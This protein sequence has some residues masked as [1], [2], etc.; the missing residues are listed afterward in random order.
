M[1]NNT[2]TIMEELLDSLPQQGEVRWLG[3]RPARGEAMT[4]TDSVEARVGTGLAG[5][6]YQGRGGKREVTLI[7]WE[8][9]SVIANLLG[10]ASVNAATLRRNI[11]VSGIN[12]L[13]LRN[14]YFRIGTAILQGVDHCHPCS[15]ME[16]ALGVGGYNAVRGHGGITAR[17]IRPGVIRRGDAVALMQEDDIL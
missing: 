5:D 8:H 1:K 15:K 16:Y 7:Q 13:A 10:V 11:A 6:R 14:Q 17:V 9:L 4:T 3:V 12:L 2:P